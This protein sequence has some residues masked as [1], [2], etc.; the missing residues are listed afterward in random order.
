M[1]LSPHHVSSIT[2]YFRPY[3]PGH[4]LLCRYRNH[5]PRG[6]WEMGS[7]W[8]EGQVWCYTPSPY[9]WPQRFSLF[10]CRMEIG[11]TCKADVCLHNPLHSSAPPC[12][13]SGPRNSS[14]PPNF[15]FLYLLSTLPALYWYV[16][17]SGW[18][19]SLYLLKYWSQEEL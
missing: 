18:D 9:L 4:V 14:M 1:P 11:G 6:G 2:Q 8:V 10:F 15:V 3:F 12:W 19:L 13:S 5:S 16:L 17:Y 7:R